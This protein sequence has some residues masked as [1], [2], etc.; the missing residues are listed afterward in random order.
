MENKMM[1]DFLL[2]LFYNVLTK[3]ISLLY[4]ISNLIRF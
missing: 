4:T 1:N 3:L 2:A